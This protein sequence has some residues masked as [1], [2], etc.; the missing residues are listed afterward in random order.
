MEKRADKVKE[1]EEKCKK[2]RHRL[3]EVVSETGGHLAPNLGIVE[4]T[5]ALHDV[6][7]SPNDK[8]LFDVGHQS[9]V[10]KL[11]TGRDEKFPTLR[12]KDGIGPF[13]D[14]KESIHDQFISGHAGSAISAGLGIAEAMHQNKNT[15]N[16]VITIIGD[17]SIASGHSLEGLNNLCGLGKNYIIIL[18][19]NEMSIGENVGAL[20]GF[21]SKVM[22]SKKYFDLKEDV[23]FLIR[24]GKV[25]NAVADVIRRVEHSVKHFV[26]P[27]S[28][29][30]KL[31]IK[32]VGPVDGHDLNE[33]L[34]N[35]ESLK[36]LDGPILFHVKTKKGKGYKYAEENVEKFHGVSPFDI[37]TGGTNSKGESYSSVFGKAMLSLGRQDKDISV[38]CAGMVKGVGLQDFF[39]EFPQRSYDVGIAEGHAVTF[40]AGLAIQKKKPYVAIYST[41]LQRSY[42]QLI[43]DVNLQNLPVRFIV[44]RAGIAGEDGKTHQGLFD[45]NYFLTMEKFTV[46][47]P[48]TSRELVEALEFS[49]NIKNPLAI[50]I[51][52]SSSF[53]ILNNKP[54]KYGKFNE[55]K[56]QN[57]EKEGIKNLFI[58]TGTMLE[59]VINITSELKARGIEATIVASP[60]INPLDEEYLIKNV[61]KYDNIFVF[62]EAYIKKFFW[63]T[64]IG[65]FK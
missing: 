33:L 24:K 49:R 50:R 30:E 10:H 40:A 45:L 65:I 16:K 62:E 34:E 53:D 4:L 15:K 64:Y 52:R 63:N 20:S 55:I 27:I 56:L 5:V 13:T 48:T 2:I 3:I 59:E 47:A 43:H 31:G 21:F 22:G 58:V 35:L 44:D 8:I 41:F 57:F 26:A 61:N 36:I 25:G 12:Q 29:S 39:D 18:N 14:P 32:Y 54:L 38:I 7:D 51:P 60:F 46:I 1:L 6:F 9:Y 11:L 19:D 37:K 42:D 23:E 17:A 28:I